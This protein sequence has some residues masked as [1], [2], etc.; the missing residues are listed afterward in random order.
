MVKTITVPSVF[1]NGED[2]DIQNN[3]LTEEYS[4]LG[5]STM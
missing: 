1:K 2:Q 4:L 5:C 3:N